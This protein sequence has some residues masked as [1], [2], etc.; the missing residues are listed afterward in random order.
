MLKLEKK[1]A[2]LMSSLF[3]YFMPS[4]LS[5]YTKC[6]HCSLVSAAEELQPSVVQLTETLLPVSKSFHKLVARK[7]RICVVLFHMDLTEGCSAGQAG[8]AC[9]LGAK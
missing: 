6:T 1:W 7:C 3:H 8:F 4:V 2:Y 9:H 5:N